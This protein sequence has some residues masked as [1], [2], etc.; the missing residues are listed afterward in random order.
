MII[1]LINFLFLLFFIISCSKNE[2]LSGEDLWYSLNISNY[3]MIQQISCFC[4]PEEFIS[5]KSIVVLNGDIHKINGSEPSETI[6]FEYYSSIN[7][8]FEFIENS[9]KEN[10]EF[11][12][13]NYN[14]KYGFPESIFFD[15]SEMI[16]D[17]EI[18][19]YITNFKILNYD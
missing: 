19:Y 1:R 11:F 14:E 8:L 5:P 6:G 18:G 12:E 7:S 16:A 13:I 2:E 15:M 9:L 10:P 4:F 3:E 17:E